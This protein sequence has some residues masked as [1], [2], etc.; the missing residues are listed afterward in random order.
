[1][2]FF[3]GEDTQLHV[4]VELLPPGSV[5]G[6]WLLVTMEDGEFLG[7]ELNHEKTQEVKDRVSA[8]RALLLERMASRKRNR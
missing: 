8:K 6:N 5:E 3:E 7:A 1:M 4:P 2:L